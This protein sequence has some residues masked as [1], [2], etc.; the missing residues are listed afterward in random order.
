MKTITLIV[1]L[2]LALH[3][4]LPSAQRRPQPP[5]HE[6]IAERFHVRQCPTCPQPR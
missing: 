4:P 2:G 1:T 5:A 3:F 6:T